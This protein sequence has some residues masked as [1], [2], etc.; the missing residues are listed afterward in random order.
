MARA[1]SGS[2]FNA[3]AGARAARRFDATLDVTRPEVLLYERQPDKSMQLVGVEYIVPFT[4][5]T[6]PNPPTLLGQTFVR[7]LTFNV[8]ALHAWVWRANPRGIFSD[9]NPNVHC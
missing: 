5:W 8:W 3:C 9:W 1:E 2:W 7:N 6:D 4:A